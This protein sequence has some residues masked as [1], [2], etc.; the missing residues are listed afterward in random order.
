VTDSANWDRVKALFDQALERA[1]AERET[2]LRGACTGHPALQAE[3]ASLLAAHEQVGISAEGSPFDAMSEAA[4]ASLAHVLQC[5]DRLGPYE[6]LAPL[7]AGGMGEVYRGRDTRLDRIVAIKIVSSTRADDPLWR[8]RFGREARAVSALN[9]PHIC[10]LHDVGHQNGRDFLVMEYLQGETLG[11][12]LRRGRLPLEEALRIAEHVADALAEAHRHD[13][14][15]RDIKPA[16]IFLTMRGDAKI[17]D[18]GLAKIALRAGLSTTAGPTT[19]ALETLTGAEGAVGT[20][21]YMS[22]EQMRGLPVDRRTDLFSFGLVLYEMVTGERPFKASSAIGI[23]DAIMHAPLRDFGDTPIPVSLKSLIRKLVEKEPADR[24]GSA[25]D[26]YGDLKALEASLAP[27]RPASLSRNAWAAI[28]VVV[29]AVGFLSGSLW[30]RSARERWALGTATP[31]I[32]RLVEAQEFAKAAALTREAR[33]VLPTDPTL[34]RLWLRA[35]RDALIDSVPP[36]AD[37]SIRPYRSDA[38]PWKNLGQTPLKKIRVP[39]EYYVWRIAKRG[40]APTFFIDGSPGA[41]QPGAHWDIDWTIKLRPEGSVPPEMVVVGGATTRLGY[42]DGQAPSVMID[43]YLIDR[44]EVTNEE[45]KKFVT[46]GGY[47]KRDFWKQPFV[48][49]G[50]SLLWEEAIGFFRDSTGRPGPST[51]EV[52]TYP[53]G[54]EKYPVGGVSWY[55]A[56]AY[57]EYAGKSLPTVYHWTNASQADFTALI[58]SGSNFRD[59]GTHPVGGRGTL[60]GFGTTDMAG[61]VKEWCWN[62]SRDGKRFI[63][64]GGFGEPPYM[65][66]FTDAQLAWD[67]RPNFG[68]RCVNLNSRPTAAAAAKIETTSRNFLNERPVSDEVFKAY[69]GLYAYDKEALNARVDETEATANWTREKVT[70][71][72]A[73]G[74]ERVIAHLF[75]PKNALPPFQPVVYFPGGFALLDDKLTPSAIEETLDF[76]MKSG[77]FLMV[78]IYK[79]TYDRRDG[80]VPGDKPGV[81]RDHMIM[82]SKDLGRSLDYLQTRQDIDGTKIAYLGFSMGAKLAPLLAVEPRFK[83]A[84]LSSGGFDLRYDLPE[85]SPFNF[86]TRVHIPVL[87]LNGRYDDNFPLESSQVPFFRLLGTPEKEK[88]HVIYEAAHGDLPHREEVR[89]SL[90]WLDKY[91]GPVRQ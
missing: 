47:Q 25:E 79:G 81:F 36:G 46:D 32:A 7:G 9:H 87:M 61:N 80:M 75:V 15:H 48:R 55:E 84:I 68:F 18:F 26:V 16:N 23:A 83:T 12:R 78:P 89:E 37:V 35:T 49:D 74:N 72:A 6:I 53:K 34:E 62:E 73:Y 51:W 64:G 45:Y 85:V 41:L 14:I 20:V 69:R 33:A 28:G 27:T 4:V 77:R 3:V 40:F 58:S 2:F 10:T 44:H 67:R 39:I 56:A 43:D 59:V 17:L 65:F 13:L 66:K 5:G 24:Y 71:D 19:T 86:V 29:V 38:D 82:W 22:P 60:S 42:P 54:R 52:G 1:P 76:L 31:E 50:R 8:E 30:H 70:F 88:K 57:A 63:L 21:A 91:L 90:D 11:D